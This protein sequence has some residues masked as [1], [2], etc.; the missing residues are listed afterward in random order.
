MRKFTYIVAIFFGVYLIVSLV[1][2]LTSLL[3]Q[4]ENIEKL[5]ESLSLE[6]KRHEELSL[7]KKY[8]ESPEFIEREAR[9]KLLLGKPGETRVII[10]GERLL[11]TLGTTSA[12]LEQ[13][14]KP[15]WQKWWELFFQ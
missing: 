14:T 7:K 3:R 15:N 2:T 11:E 1:Q 8:V 6:K 13:E 9:E 10:D 12:A 4:R 5:R